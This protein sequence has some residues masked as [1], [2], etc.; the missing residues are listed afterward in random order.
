MTDVAS[1]EA[2]RIKRAASGD[3]DAFGLLVSE[4][5]PRVV[6][7]AY[8]IV[9]SLQEAEEVAQEV[10]V[11][12]WQ[13][14]PDYNQVGAF[15]SW[16]YRI[17]VNASIDRLRRRRDEASL[18]EFTQSGGTL[19][20]ASR[21]ER[22][23]PEETVVREDIARIVREA[24]EELPPNARAT[25]ILREYEQLSYKEIAE[26]LDIPIGTVMS[27]LNYARQ[28]LRRRLIE[29]KHLDET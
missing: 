9:G 13:S 6:R 17:T 19:P 4:H 5:R 2:E 26:A 24:I 16:L 1:S 8:G 29:G 23:L 22:E 11:K 20:V 18:D 3:M 14:L 25:L 12:A 21:G 27:R 10:F 15:S 28:V 7:T